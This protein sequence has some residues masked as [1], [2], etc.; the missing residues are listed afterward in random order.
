M[1]IFP[2]KKWKYFFV[3]IMRNIDP[4]LNILMVNFYSLNLLQCLLMIH[5][6]IYDESGAYI[7][8]LII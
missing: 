5:R 1:K 6:L 3:L 7:E 4:L 2:L 8:L